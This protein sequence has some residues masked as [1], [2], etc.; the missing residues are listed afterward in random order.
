MSDLLFDPAVGV[1]QK[2]AYFSP[3]GTDIGNVQ[4]LTELALSV[5]SAM[6]DGVSLE[7]TLPSF[8]PVKRKPLLEPG[9]SKGCPV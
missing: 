8:I 2:G 1:V 7:E 6:A 5:R 4:G 9:F 3:A